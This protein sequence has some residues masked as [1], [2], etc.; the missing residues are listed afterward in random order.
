MVPFVLMR[1]SGECSLSGIERD[2]SRKEEGPQDYKCFLPVAGEAST[3]AVAPLVALSSAGLPAS[4]RQKAHAGIRSRRHAG[5]VIA[6]Q[7][8]RD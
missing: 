7:C 5:D 1:E 4:R 2:C 3:A 6:A 8:R